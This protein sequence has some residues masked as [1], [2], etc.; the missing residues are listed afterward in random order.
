MVWAIFAFNLLRAGHAYFLKIFKPKV[1]LFHA[2]F[3]QISVLSDF[4]AWQW[5][6]YA[7]LQYRAFNGAKKH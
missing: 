3:H 4:A 2:F 1:L 7:H 5:S 6:D